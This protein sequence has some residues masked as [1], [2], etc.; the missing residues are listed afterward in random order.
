LRQLVANAGLEGSVVVAHLSRERRA[1]W[2]F[3]VV[4]EQY[5]DLVKAG[6]IDPAKVA[7]CALEN[8][9]SVAG[10]ILSTEALVTDLADGESLAAATGPSGI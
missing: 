10:M 9:A 3:D 5:L 8:A 4:S 2:G 7:R 1:N 6:I